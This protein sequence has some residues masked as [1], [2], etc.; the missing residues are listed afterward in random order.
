MPPKRSFALWTVIVVLIGSMV[1]TACGAGG[2]S[3]VTTI[4][5]DMTDHQFTPDEFV[6]PAGAEI[7][8][9]LKNS[10]KQHHEF[11]ILVLG[12]KVDEDVDKDGNS[13]RYW[14]TILLPGDHKSLSFTAPSESGNYLIK[15][16]APG[17][18]QAGMT[19]TLHVK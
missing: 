10:G 16:S 6:V 17:H 19:G 15:C 7:T 11:R 3:P 14:S 8:I 5:V 12:A 13:T 18:T 4:D 1:F 2:N 9:N